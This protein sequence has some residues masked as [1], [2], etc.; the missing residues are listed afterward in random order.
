MS[1]EYNKLWVLLEKKNM[2]KI[3]LQRAARI[4]GNILARLGNDDYVSLETIEKICKTLD[5]TTDCILEFK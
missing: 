1:V 3:Q 5:C 2:K 4:S